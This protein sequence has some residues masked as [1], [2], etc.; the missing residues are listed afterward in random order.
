VVPV[1]GSDVVAAPFEAV[2]GDFAS[3]QAAGQFTFA[4]SFEQ[5]VRVSAV[6]VHV[7]SSHPVAGVPVASYIPPATFGQFP[8]AE[9]PV[10]AL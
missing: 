2:T 4:G 9:A 10:W 7:A 5:S 8:S 3:R 6:V 1:A